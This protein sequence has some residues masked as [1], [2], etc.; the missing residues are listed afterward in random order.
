M[1]D[2]VVLAYPERVAPMRHVRGTLLIG[3]IATLRENG[4]FDGYSRVVR[5][6]VLAT[7]QA[8]VSAMWIPIDIA[9]AHFEACDSLGISAESAAQLGRS[10][11]AR[12]RGLL[13]G[14]ATAIARHAGASPLTLAPHLGRFWN[15]A[16]DGGAV[17]VLKKGPKEMQMEVQQCALAGFRYYRSALRGLAT[18]VYELVAEKVYMS[19]RPSSRQGPPGTTLAFRVQWV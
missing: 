13:M 9:V 10:T 12:T 7:I 17:Q 4:Y 16:Y 15:R 1:E 5:P 14:T 11:F 2:E 3:S 18:A 6:D 8:S 19:E